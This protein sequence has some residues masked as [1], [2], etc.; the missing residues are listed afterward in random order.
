ME[1]NLKNIKKEIDFLQKE[2]IGKKLNDA[3]ALCN[4]CRIRVGEEDGKVNM[5]TMEYSFNRLNVR[6]K[7]GVIDSI[8]S[9]S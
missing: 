9:I 2:I 8:I 3:L 6:I 4:Y 7:N 1:D 5:G